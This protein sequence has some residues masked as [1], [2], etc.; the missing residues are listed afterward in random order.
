MTPSPRRTDGTAADR[1]SERGGSPTPLA[2]VER[3]PHGISRD[4]RLRISDVLAEL[5]D[6]FPAV[7]PSKLRFLEDQG[8]VEPV[9][10]PSG[11][12]QYSAADVERIRY[13]LTQQR[14]SYMPLKVIG[15]KLAE[16]DRGGHEQLPTLRA[17]GGGMPQLHDAGR[18]TVAELAAECATSADFV[19]GLVESGFVSLD[20]R[21]SAPAS[22]SVIVRA[23]VTL[24]EHG[25]EGRHLSAMLGAVRR[26][27]DLVAQAVAPITA[28]RTSTS[29]AHAS[30][31]QGELAETLSAV[32]AALM[33]NAISELDGN[34]NL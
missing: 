11:Y 3:W 22:A 33:R 18:S 9:R 32:H 31:L 12:R 5:K 21:G 4:A 19:A 30:A 17:A 6:E 29:S 27:V 8:L 20:R 14:D 1:S 10:T 2:R 23:M 28:K 13:I 25:I 26:E 15:D 7:S 24:Q 34:L 16:L